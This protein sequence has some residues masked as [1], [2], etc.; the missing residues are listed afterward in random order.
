MGCKE[1]NQSNKKQT[2]LLWVNPCPVEPGYVIFR[3]E[4][5][6]RISWLNLVNPSVD[7][8][9]RSALLS[10]Q[11]KIHLYYIAII[12]MNWLETEI[13]VP[14]HLEALEGLL[15][16]LPIHVYYMTNFPV[17]GPCQLIWFP[18]FGCRQSLISWKGMAKYTLSIQVKVLKNHF[19]I[20]QPKNNFLDAQKSRL[21]ETVLLSTQNKGSNGWKIASVLTILSIKV[22]LSG[23][24]FY[25]TPLWKIIQLKIMHFI[26]T[27]DIWLYQFSI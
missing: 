16:A 7:R 27:E 2:M 9:S 20:S 15:R 8:K 5:R 21:N 11:H 3:K 18:W 13:N 6:W 14:Y 10:R 25:Q 24:M 26:I 4:C 1:S 12:Q 23:P 19:V 22:H 17:W